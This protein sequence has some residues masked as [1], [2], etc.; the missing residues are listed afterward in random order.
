MRERERERERERGVELTSDGAAE[1]AVAAVSEV[2]GGWEGFFPYY[3][4]F[5]LFILKE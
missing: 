1:P 2:G 4:F 3:Y 5:F